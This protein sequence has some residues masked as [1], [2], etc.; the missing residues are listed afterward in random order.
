MKKAIILIFVIK[1]VIIV[2]F[3]TCFFIWSKA[4]EKILLDPMVILKIE[5]KLNSANIQIFGT[6]I[7]HIFLYFVALFV[8][9]TT[10]FIVGKCI[11]NFN[12]G[13]KNY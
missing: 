3:A 12:R 5:S 10:G 2:L 6:N 13:I 9:I 8:C 4:I 11:G 1:L 7:Y